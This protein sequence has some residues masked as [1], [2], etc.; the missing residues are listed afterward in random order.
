MRHRAGQGTA[1]SARRSRTATSRCRSPAYFLGRAR[2]GRGHL[3]G[4]QLRRRQGALPVAGPGRARSCG[5]AASCIDAKEVPGRRAGDHPDH[6]RARR[7]RQ[8]GRDRRHDLAGTS[9]ELAGRVPLDRQGRDRHRRRAAASAR[10]RTDLRRSRRRR[11][12]RGPHQGAARRGRRR[13]A[14]LRPARAGDPVRRQR[15]RRRSKTSSRRPM[16][17]FGRI[18]IVVNNAGGTM[19]RPFMDTS[20]GLPRARRSTSTSRPRSC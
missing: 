3:D 1:R 7:R 11:R 20:A 13:R 16:A 12:A 15:E 8:A 5:A 4:H 9:Y 6:D 10:D 2:A 17:E 14:R 19:P 18:D